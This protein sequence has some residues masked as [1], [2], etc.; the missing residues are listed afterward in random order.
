MSSFWAVGDVSE[1]LRRLESDLDSGAWAQRYSELL[2]LDE[3]DCGYR[4]VMTR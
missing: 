4:L 1:A 3:C 2:D